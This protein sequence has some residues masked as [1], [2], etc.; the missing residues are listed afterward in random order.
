MLRVFIVQFSSVKFLKP[1]S[2]KG[3]TTGFIKVDYPE[4]ELYKM[5]LE[6][7]WSLYLKYQLS[8]ASELSPN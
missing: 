2:Q 7:A 8:S 4:C 5:P 6:R 1:F 3:Q